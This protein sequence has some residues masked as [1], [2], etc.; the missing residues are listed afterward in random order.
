[1]VGALASVRRG[2]AV[3][4]RIATDVELDRLV[5]A[6]GRRHL[7]TERLARQAQG[8]GELF[9]AWDGAEPVG[10]GYLWRELVYA[11]RVARELGFVPTLTNL[12]VLPGRRGEGVGTALVAGIERMAVDLGYQRICLGVG[13]DNPGARRLYD[14]LGYRDWGHGSVVVEWDSPETGEHHSLE[15]DWLVKVLPGPAPDQDLW[16]PWRPEEAAARLAGCPVPWAVAGGWAI[17]LHLGRQT[18][19]HEDLEI[20]I[21]RA[22]LE[23]YL[24]YLRGLDLYSVGDGRILPLAGGEPPPYH[25]LWASDGV[26]RLDTF[27]EPGD[28]QTWIS[29]RDERV[30][31]PMDL[32]VRRDASGT[33]YLA[34]ETVLFA[35]AKHARPKDESDLTNALPSL[36]AASRRWLVDALELAH[37]GHA[38]L[39]RL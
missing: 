16:E 36:D 22:D 39:G 26:W 4:I 3:E 6:F 31:L 24:P 28:G 7:F 23:R 27:L 18:R 10:H 30:R 29:H 21:P 8:L 13:V 19:E 15:C 38:W 1:M 9:V 17:D 20:A 2:Y 5:G 34:P 33:P 35:K 37:P 11:E 32:A 25:Q 12:D 14:R